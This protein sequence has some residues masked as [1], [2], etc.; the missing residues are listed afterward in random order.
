MVPF[1]FFKPRLKSRGMKA[2]ARI[3]KSGGRMTQ[4]PNG[5]EGESRGAREVA[6]GGSA[7]PHLTLGT[8]HL[9]RFAFK[10]FLKGFEAI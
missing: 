6:K 1:S 3:Q 7:K 5:G 4:N 9:T 10:A 8:W 2:E